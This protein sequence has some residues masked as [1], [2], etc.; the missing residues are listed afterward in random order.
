MLLRKKGILIAFMLSQIL[1]QFSFFFFT[2]IKMST[3]NEKQ[4]SGNQTNYISNGVRCLENIANIPITRTKLFNYNTA[5]DCYIDFIEY[6]KNNIPIR[7]L[8]EKFPNS[9]TYATHEMILTPSFVSFLAM[10]RLRKILEV[11]Q[12]PPINEIDDTY[13]H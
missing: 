1:I 3:N 7:K 12:F 2:K 5:Y 10:K 4:N 6:S 11:D 8:R 9:K 13:N